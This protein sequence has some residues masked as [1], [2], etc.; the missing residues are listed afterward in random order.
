MVSYGNGAVATGR[1]GRRRSRRA[2]CPEFGE[3]EVVVRG[4]VVLH[5]RRQVEECGLRWA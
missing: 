5:V 4:D 1:S 2:R 3:P